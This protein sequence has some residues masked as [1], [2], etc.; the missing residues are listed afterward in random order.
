MKYFV[1]HLHAQTKKTVG[2][3]DLGGGS[4]QIT[5]L[6]KSQVG[7]LSNL[8]V[9][10]VKAPKPSIGIVYSAT[11]TTRITTLHSQK[12]IQSAP[13]DYIVRFDMF[14]STYELYTHR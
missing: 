5:F 14:N 4:T 13:A 6:P 7:T 10:G 12:T 2:I 11:D 1:G 3:L 9:C 8:N